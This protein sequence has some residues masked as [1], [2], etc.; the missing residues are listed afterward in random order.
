MRVPA[1]LK[2]PWLSGFDK[3]VDMHSYY[4][5]FL[6]IPDD[7]D[8]RMFGLFLMSKLPEEAELLEVDLHLAHGRIVKT[9]LNRLG[10]ISFDKEEV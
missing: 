8:Y 4:I 6:P 2:E 7:R 9:G 5:R 1:L 10:L 3:K